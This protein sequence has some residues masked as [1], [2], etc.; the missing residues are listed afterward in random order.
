MDTNKNAIVNDTLVYHQS[1]KNK[2]SFLQ[3]KRQ[4]DIWI[5]LILLILFLPLML[6]VS[7]IIII[8]SKGPILF[9]Q[10][11]IGLDGSP[12]QMYKFRTMHTISVS[13]N[14]NISEK[15]E[16][17][18]KNKAIYNPRTTSIGKY[19]RKYS[20]D[21]LP[22]LINVIKGDMS[23]VG[24]RPTMKS[25]YSNSYQI[26][27]RTVVL[28]GMTGLWQIRDRANCSINQQLKYDIEYI[29]NLSFRLDIYILFKT[30]ST[31]VK[32]KGF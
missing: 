2:R 7:F 12:F 29:E 20:I 17:D 5:A 21:E 22:Q 15:A 11:R 8:T 24:P 6:I 18:F 9:M 27:V 16:D 4:F 26:K 28:P 14:Q 23:L 30:I 31:V 32:G 19:L 25:L 3:I 1:I 10:E 13:H